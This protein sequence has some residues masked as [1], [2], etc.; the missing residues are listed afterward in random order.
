MAEPGTYTVTVNLDKTNVSTSVVVEEDPRIQIS[1]ADRAERRAAIVRLY[2]LSG[3]AFRSLQNVSKLRA[4]LTAALDEWKKAG[5]PK[6]PEDIKGAAETILKK[7][8]E[9]QEKFVDAPLPE[10]WAGPPLEVRP[11]TIPARLGNLTGVIDAYTGAPT[12]I[13]KKEM[14][15]VAK[16]VEE[17]G[18]AIDGLL[19]K[20]LVELNKKMNQAGIAHIR[21]K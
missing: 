9:L 2:E 13:Q 3:R 12:D 18:K 6:I 11:P 1:A 19:E 7:S 10:G 8:V 14:D 5:A 15:L 16:L 21:I 4:A 17:A 20:D